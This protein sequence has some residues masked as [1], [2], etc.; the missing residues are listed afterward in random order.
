MSGSWKK[1]RLRSLTRYVNNTY[2]VVFATRYFVTRSLT[3][4]FSLQVS[5]GAVQG[6]RWTME[7]EYKVANGGRFAA[8]FDGHGG[9]DVSLILRER[10]YD[11]YCKWLSKKHWEER[12]DFHLEKS[13][14]PSISSHVAAL[15]GAIEQ[16]DKDVLKEEHLIHQGST[17]VAVVVHV[18]ED[19]HRTLLSAN[20]GDSRAILSRGGKAIDLTWDHKPNEERE[21]SRIMARGE[22]VQWDAHAQVHR[23]RN[24]SLSRAIGDKFA[25][26]AVSGEPEIRHFPVSD[27]DDEFFLL[28][29]DG[30]W[31]VMS[32]QEVV[33]YIHQTLKQEKISESLS[34]EERATL[35]RVQYTR[36]A[37]KVAREA[38]ERGTSDNVCV[39]LVW[40]G[41]DAVNK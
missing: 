26:P 7:D 21:R 31:D 11:E 30:L 3:Y 37:R 8:V 13:R 20:V 5:A 41:E 24:L 18:G 32:S 6:A 4:Y 12:D 28:A 9:N 29:S 27:K 39:L 14:T 38:L 40:L 19:G 25:K 17:A 22:E 2:L 34:E 1:K 23:V 10:L 15:R 33:D 35:K 16:V 36:M